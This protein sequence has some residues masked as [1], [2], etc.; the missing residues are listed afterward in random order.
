MQ[1]TIRAARYYNYGNFDQEL[2]MHK[3]NSH[4][5]E[6]DGRMLAD[7]QVVARELSMLSTVSGETT[8]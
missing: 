8:L 6:R 7:C 1:M 3:Q 2:S 5:E 4:N